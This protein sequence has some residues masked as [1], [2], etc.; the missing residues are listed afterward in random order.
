MLECKAGDDCSSFYYSN[1]H[2]IDCYFTFVG[3]KTYIIRKKFD[4]G[5][6]AE[7]S[8]IVDEYLTKGDKH[9]S[10]VDISFCVYRKRKKAWGDIVESTGKDGLKPLVWAKECLKTL[11]KVIEDDKGI[12]N[13]LWIRRAD[14]IAITVGWADHRRRDLY[15]KILFREGYHMSNESKQKYLVKYIKIS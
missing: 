8:F 1:I 9:L 5:M 15:Q 2:N 13:P 12:F 6:T 11:E 10:L 4:S 3:D 14:N 7:F